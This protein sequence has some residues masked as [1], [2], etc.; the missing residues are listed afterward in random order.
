MKFESLTNINPVRRMEE[1][2]TECDFQQDFAGIGSAT[3]KIGIVL[4]L[5]SAKPH[6]GTPFHAQ[7]L[8]D[9]LN[10]KSVENDQRNHSLTIS[11]AAEFS[12]LGGVDVEQAFVVTVEADDEIARD[13]LAVRLKLGSSSFLIDQWIETL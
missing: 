7:A 1:K 9:C 12:G 6:H 3:Q 5:A 13:S 10:Q 2:A 4:K 8:V 11:D